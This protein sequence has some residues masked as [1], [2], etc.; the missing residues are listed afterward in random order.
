MKL[1]KLNRLGDDEV[2][3]LQP[4]FDNLRET[5][6][7]DGKYRLRRYSVIELRTSFWN[8][9]IEAEISRLPTRNFSQSEEINKH[10][11]GMSRLFEE[12]EDNALFSEGM[13]A[14]CLEFKNHYDL[15]D[16]QEIEIHQMRVITLNNESTPVSPEG[17][18]QDGFDCI[19]MLG[20]NRHNVSGG[21]LMV[22]KHQGSEPFM[23][24]TLCN[25]DMAMLNDSKLWHNATPIVPWDDAEGGSLDLFVFCANK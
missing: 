22:Y 25:G 6:H 8:A 1:L 11:G 23:T 5:P 9:K 13:K 21:E 7:K 18:H 16:G 14:A 19:A 4:S 2:E 24:Y 15:V 20:V 17:I 12:I 10:Q 3:S